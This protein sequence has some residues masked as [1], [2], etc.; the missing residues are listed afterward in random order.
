MNSC[1]EYAKYRAEFSFG[2]GLTVEWKRIM[3]GTF[4]LRAKHKA[5]RSCSI[6][7]TRWKMP[8]S[9]RINFSR[10][11]PIA[12]YLEP[13][14]GVAPKTTHT[15]TL[16]IKFTPQSWPQTRL[17]ALVDHSFLP[18]SQVVNSSASLS[19]RL[20]RP[21]IIPASRLPRRSLR[22]EILEPPVQVKSRTPQAFHRWVSTPFPNLM[23][24]RAVGPDHQCQERKAVAR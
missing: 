12:G 24:L 11:S 21:V 4:S 17:L 14:R 5:H 6:L 13:T 10:F 9:N 1:E 3:E 15:P 22:E 18:I 19:L 16:V 20:I 2:F 8:I 7:L 23:T